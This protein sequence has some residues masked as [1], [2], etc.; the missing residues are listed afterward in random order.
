MVR[1]QLLLFMKIFQWNKVNAVIAGATLALIA[2]VLLQAQWLL[3][4]KNLIEEQ[5]NQKVSMA[6]CMAVTELGDGPK[7]CIASPESEQDLFNMLTANQVTTLPP[8]SKK[9][10]VKKALDNALAFYD[11]HL[12]YEVEIFDKKETCASEN[13][14]S[15]CSLGMIEGY[16]DQFLNITFPHRTQFILGQMGFMIGSSIFILLF[17]S[18]VFGL[19]T[20][21]LIQQK[22]IGERNKDF[23]NN[24]AHEFK[25][26]LTNIILANKLLAKKLPQLSSNSFVNITKKEANKLMHQVERVLYLANMERN[27]YA[28]NK[29]ELNLSKL[30]REVIEDMAIQIDEKQAIIKVDIPHDLVVKGDK[31]HLSNAFRNLI[32]N[33]LKYATATPTLHIT[34]EI[35][36]KGILLLFKDNGI[37]MAKSEQAIVFDKFQ[38]VGTGDIHNQKGFGLG[39]AYV[40]KVVELHQGFIHIFSELNKGSRFDLYLPKG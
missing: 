30:L 11:I 40:K 29:E 14:P 34:S 32:D 19:A 4:S 35:K 24:M 12:A 3:H 16:N 6:L 23:F 5:F 37:G 7:T 25:T 28:L 31:F 10:E 9:Q 36:D 27:D 21:Y 17:V 18:T 22:K 1:A 2:L 39:L 15:C 20:Y 8:H 38:R 33:A 26:P 13:S